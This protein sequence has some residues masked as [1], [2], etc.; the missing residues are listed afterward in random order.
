M[1]DLSRP[2][3][4][5]PTMTALALALA[6]GLGG[7]MPAGAQ[8]L[9]IALQD[10]PDL[11][12]PAPGKSFVGRI[13]FNSLCDKL[14]DVSPDL[15]FVPRLATAW[16]WSEDGKALTFTLREGA[17]FHDGE[18]IDAEA[19]KYNIER[20]KT[21]PES[22]RKSELSGVETVDAVDAKTVRFNLKAPDVSLIATLSDRAGMMI[23]PKAAKAAGADFGLKPVCS[24]PYKFA[25][26]V[27][28]DR[29]V[30]E[31]NPDHWNA[32]NFFFDKI[33]YRN[34]RDATVRLAN[35]R[36][37]DF[38]IIERLE[39]TDVKDANADKNVKVESAVSL[40]YQGITFNLANGAGADNPF[41]K[42]KRLRQAMSLAI[43]RKAL[44][45]VVFEGQFTPGVQPVPPVSPYYSKL[46]PVPAPDIA[47][48][49]A[50]V[51]AAGYDRVKAEMKFANNPRTQRLVEVIQAM[52]GEAGIDLALAAT[53]FA[54][55]MAD[56]TKGTFQ[57]VQIGWS[58]R[59]DPDGNIH[60]FMTCKG[61]LNDGKYCSAEVD[62]LLNE[63]RATPD[64]AKRLAAYEAAEKIYLDDLPIIYLYYETWIW[65]MNKKVQGF[66]PSPD[67]MIRLDGV[68]LVN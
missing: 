14:I 24:G 60:S 31:R 32:K 2:A 44:N 30:L 4:T 19:V 26:R 25:E 68:K 1:S 28:Q 15:K 27:Q 54:T 3:C 42:D 16:T 56:Q 39:P 21:L 55:Q 52:V 36:A 37:G 40:G 35:L 5:S 18:P 62:R 43:D 34:V 11:L 66:V 49:R 63:A 64:F 58:G 22:I 41:A 23:S 47:K 17:K 7:A 10:D 48:A 67:G 45:E 29:I 20:S 65:A 59:P 38:D 61:G 57:T 46:F 9:R 33:I 51:K 6:L 8:T 53:E 13:V 50:L 12:D